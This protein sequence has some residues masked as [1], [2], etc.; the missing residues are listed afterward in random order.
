MAAGFERPDPNGSSENGEA[1]MNF[2]FKDGYKDAFE[3]KTC[4][5]FV[6]QTI[7]RNPDG[8]LIVKKTYDD[9]YATHDFCVSCVIQSRTSAEVRHRSRMM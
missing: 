8:S 4:N 9:V 2:N 3:G 5:P 6:E 7:S 1:L